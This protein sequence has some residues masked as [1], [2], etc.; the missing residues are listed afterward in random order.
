MRMLLPR[1]SHPWNLSEGSEYRQKS[2]G[3]SLA[4]DGESRPRAM[5]VVQRVPNSYSGRLEICRRAKLGL[6]DYPQETRRLLFISAFVIRPSS[7]YT[8]VAP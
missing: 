3:L 2:I 5:R 8:A 6:P 1:L 4:D 7:Q